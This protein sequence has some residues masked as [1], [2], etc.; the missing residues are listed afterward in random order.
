VNRH[1]SST[2]RHSSKSIAE[3][4]VEIAT[5]VF[6]KFMDIRSSRKTIYGLN[7]HLLFVVSGVIINIIVLLVVVSIKADLQMKVIMS[8]PAVDVILT[9]IQSI[10]FI[11]LADYVIHWYDKRF[12]NRPNS[13]LRYV[14]EVAT[15]LILGFCIIEVV[16]GAY[17]HVFT[18]QKITKEFLDDAHRSQIIFLDFLLIVYAF[19]R[20]FHF[21]SFLKSKEIEMIKWKKDISMS[22]YESLKNQLNPHFLFNSFSVLIGLIQTDAFKADEFI[23][24]LSKAYRYLLEQRDKE[25]IALGS[26]LEF[27]ENFKFILSQRFGEKIK[28]SVGSIYSESAIVIPYTLI[29]LVEHLIG[30]NKMSDKT[31][32]FIDISTTAHSLKIDHTHAP[33]TNRKVSEQLLLL[34]ER[35]EQTTGRQVSI[36]LSEGKQI[37]TIP[38][39]ATT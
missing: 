12:S 26:E 39:L 31:P 10:A 23:G 24:R 6:A 33:K 34:Q 19:M 21:F 36:L 16:M 3:L 15:V 29:L 1:S 37:I 38:V 25:T 14:L 22:N 7:K 27:L 2:F 17:I 13:F 30:V 9:T 8:V 18:N 5:L 20:G 35:Y 32:L 4:R 28:I 11:Y